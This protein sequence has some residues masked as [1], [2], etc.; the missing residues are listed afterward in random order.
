MSAAAVV[1]LG[2]G[3]LVS[4]PAAAQSS[5]SLGQVYTSS[6]TA[7]HYKRSISR[8]LGEAPPASP[9]VVTPVDGIVGP[10]GLSPAAIPA[11]AASSVQVT[12]HSARGVCPPLGFHGL[13][14]SGQV[15]VYTQSGAP[16]KALAADASGGAAWDETDAAGHPVAAG[17]YFAQSTG[18]GKSHWTQIT[19]IR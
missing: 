3:L 1:S 2:V 17:V 10:Q 13:T 14:S 5:A 11:K 12:C 6:A 15:I 4:S 9:S 7:A 16:V 19:L 18:A 8:L